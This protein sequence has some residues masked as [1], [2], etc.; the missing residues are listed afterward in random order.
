[1]ADRFLWGLSFTIINSH[2]RQPGVCRV[3]YHIHLILL[4]KLIILHISCF[5]FETVY[6]RIH[7]S[8]IYNL[9]NDVHCIFI[10][11]L[12]PVLSI[13]HYNG[14][15][16]SQQLQVKQTVRHLSASRLPIDYR[17]VTD[18]LHNKIIIAS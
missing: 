4:I 1:M 18:R 9:T 2:N 14:H 13:L 5:V 8:F 17:Q 6:I 10:S 16:T 11:S 7:A 15:P 12:V 3:F